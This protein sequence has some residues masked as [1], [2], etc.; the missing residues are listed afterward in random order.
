VHHRIHSTRTGDDGPLV[1]LT[2][3]WGDTGETW[4]HQVPVLA[5]RARV[6]TWDLLGHGRSDG[7]DDPSAYSHERALADLDAIVG[8]DRAILVGHSFGGQLSLSFTLRHPDRVAALG[9]IGTGPG[10][11]DPVGRQ[12][13][14]DRIERQARDSEAKGERAR[15]HSIRGFVTQHDSTIMDGAPSITQPA[16]VIVGAKDTAFLAAADWFEQKLANA[17]KLVVPDA[18]HAVFRHQPEPVNRALVGLIAAARD[19]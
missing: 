6:V 9:L 5:E 18:G 4:S 13:W 2:H 10:Y 8:D 3:G 1:V 19:A 12:A 14:N 7:P 17:T 15:A 16:A 11:R